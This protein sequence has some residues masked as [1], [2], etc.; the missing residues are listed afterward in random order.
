[1]NK[2]EILKFIGSNPMCHLATLDG[3]RPRVRGMMAFRATADGIVFS[4]GVSKQLYRQINE[5]KQVELCFNS[6]DTQVR[7]EGEV[8]ILDDLGLKKE[9]VEAMPFLK[10]VVEQF[11]YETLGLFRVKMC[12]AAV[13]TMTANMEPTVFK[14]L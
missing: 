11:G 14:E 4:T 3:G 1:M 12:K 2:E 10:P 8:E 7:I 6:P 13:W 5:N 9:I